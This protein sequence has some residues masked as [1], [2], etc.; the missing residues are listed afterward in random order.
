[1]PTLKEDI[2]R[3]IKEYATNIFK[4]LRNIAKEATSFRGN[5]PVNNA[6]LTTF[7]SLHGNRSNIEEPMI[8]EMKG[9]LDAANLVLMLFED[10]PNNKLRNTFIAILVRN[11]HVL[12]AN[13]HFANFI[14]QPEFHRVVHCILVHI[15][16]DGCAIQLNDSKKGKLRKLMDISNWKHDV[17]LT[18]PLRKLTDPLPYEQLCAVCTYW[19]RE[20]P[21]NRN[22][23]LFEH[24]QLRVVATSLCRHCYTCIKRAPGGPTG[25]ESYPANGPGATQA[26]R[27]SAMRFEPEYGLQLPSP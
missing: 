27:F 4:N 13:K 11:V 16:H 25:N 22:G 21:V 3:T 9:L 1:M 2:I 26:Q 14:A 23:L 19:D 8:E 20:P 7:E 5:T 17:D 24:S 15:L 12:F 18:Y 10:Q 6:L